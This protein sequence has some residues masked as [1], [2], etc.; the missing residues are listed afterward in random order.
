MNAFQG[1]VQEIHSSSFPVLMIEPTQN[2]LKSNEKYTFEYD[3]NGNLTKKETL[4]GEKVIW[5][6]EYDLFNRLMKVKKNDSVVA[7]YMYDESGLRIKKTSPDS[8]IYYVFDAGGNVLYEQE[9]KEYMEYV[10]VLGKHFAR[11]DG[12]LD[13]G[14][15]KKYFYHTDH[16]GSTVLVTDEVGQQ[17]WS[18][19]YTPFGKQVS[20]EGELDGAAKFTGK[21]LDEDTGLY[22][23]NARWYDQEVGRFVSEDQVADPNN[24]NLY[25]YV[26][27]NPLTLTDS[28]GNNIDYN[29]EMMQ[30]HNYESFWNQE[31]YFTSNWV[32]DS[33]KQAA[34]RIALQSEINANGKIVLPG[35]TN[36]NKI[37]ALQYLAGA[38]DTGEYTSATT[39]VIQTIQT[40][41]NIMGSKPYEVDRRTFSAIL[42]RFDQGL[43]WKSSGNDIKRMGIGYMFHEAAYV[44]LGSTAMA[45]GN[46]S[47]KGEPADNIYAIENETATN[48]N[49]NLVSGQR[50]Q[51]ILNGDATGGGHKWSL[52]TIF[53]GKTKFPIN[54]S[55]EKIMNNISDI[56]IDPIAN[57]SPVWTKGA[58]GSL[59]TKS[60][61]PSR[62]YVEGVREGV[63]IRVVIEPATG[64]IITAFPVK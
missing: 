48:G 50:T 38:L 60:G 20:K 44:L 47:I 21:D 14:I 6:Y 63:K 7:E 36:S 27:N 32:L 62:F 52:T 16:L 58:N 56:A 5:K 12:N 34:S 49:V 31:N 25:A 26:A 1:G 51:H 37:A 24:L 40:K 64:N 53:N 17:V 57:K 43:I 11:V 35:E 45:K 8:A 13:N 9:N 61:Q 4:I 39:D 18:V 46:S 29:A 22:Y 28:T 54:W 55:N 42:D 3:A 19:E 23:F 30:A 10:Y 59:Y 33:T 41:Y 2:R 15:E